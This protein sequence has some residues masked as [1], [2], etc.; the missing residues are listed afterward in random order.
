M[1]REGGRGPGAP[2]GCVPCPRVPPFFG[3][4]LRAGVGGGGCWALAAFGRHRACRLLVDAVAAAAKAHEGACHAPP[5]QAN[6]TPPHR[7]AS[8]TTPRLGLRRAVPLLPFRPPPP[9]TPSPPPLH[10]SPALSPAPHSPP[11]R[12]SPCR[13]ST[14]TL[15]TSSEFFWGGG[16]AGEMMPSAR[17]PFAC[18][19]GASKLMT[20]MH[21]CACPSMHGACKHA[22]SCA[23]VAVH[24]PC[25]PSRCRCSALHATQPSAPEGPRAV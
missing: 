21:V 25:M 19:G 18:C 14:A 16:R 12:P 2:A 9:F 5:D 6:P 24:S 11:P 7:A 4:T 17:V 10:P 8:A 22:V 3:F 13:S 23:R 20:C 1:R 15:S